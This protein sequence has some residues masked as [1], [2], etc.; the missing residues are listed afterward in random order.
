MKR[1]DLN[2][3]YELVKDKYCLNHGWSSIEPDILVKILLI[4]R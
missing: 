4:Q 3:P 1:L 2:F